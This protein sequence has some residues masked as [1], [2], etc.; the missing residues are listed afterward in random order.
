[1][2]ETVVCEISP[3]VSYAGEVS[4]IVWMAVFCCCCLG[5]EGVG[6][7]ESYRF[8]FIKSVSL[9]LYTPLPPLC[10][11]GGG[12]EYIGIT[13]SICLSVMLSLCSVLSGQDLLNLVNYHEA[14]CHAKN[15]FAI[16]NVKVTAKAYVIKI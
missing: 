7:I 8:W 9:N 3:L 5:M 6:R 13:V 14:E 12:G 11:C 10:W 15:W 2:D 4:D 1:M 16:L